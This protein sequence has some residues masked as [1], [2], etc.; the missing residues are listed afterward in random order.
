MKP[1]N[2]TYHRP[3]QLEE[4]FQLLETYADEAK[5]IAGGQSLVP[6]MNMRL[7]R[8]EHLIDINELPNLGYVRKTA[9]TLQIGA[10]VRQ[11]DLEQSPELKEG[12]PI[13]A[14]AIRHVGHLAIRQRGTIGGSIAHADPAAEMPLM[15]ALFNANLTIA[16]SEGTRVVPAGDFFITIYTTDLLPNE[17]VTQVEFPLMKPSDGWSYQEFSRRRGDFAIVSV[18]TILSL[19]SAGSVKRIQMALGG[20]DLIPINV[21]ASLDGFLGVKPD[22]AWM[23]SIADTVT[24]GLDL[25]SD[26]HGSAEDRLEWLQ[27]LVRKSLQQSLERAKLE[28]R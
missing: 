27:L 16:S 9:D 11:A 21:S 1:A 19:D 26:L 28:E 3:S 10:L 5:V 8:P 4:A 15:A 13:I 6:M 22:Q 12:C 23:D 24:E 14:E 2:F 7:A 25:N 20:A 18:A 17:L